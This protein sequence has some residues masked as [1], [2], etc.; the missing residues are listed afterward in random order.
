MSFDRHTL[1]CFD[2]YI[3]LHCHV[4]K[5]TFYFT[6]MFWKI[7]STSLPCFKRYI[8]LHCHVLTD[9]F[10]FTAMFWKIHS[11]ALPCFEKYI[12]LH[13]HVLTDKFYFTAMFWAL[14]GCYSLK[15]SAEH[16]YKEQLICNNLTNFLIRYVYGNSVTA[17]QNEIVYRNVYHLDKKKYYLFETKPTVFETKPNVFVAFKCF[18]YS[19]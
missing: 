13:C 15:F 11:T 8:L 3:L 2:R 14:G 19:G 9:T 12:L 4:L 1:P 10:Y 6:A 5:D 17:W 7:H 18:N 16:Y